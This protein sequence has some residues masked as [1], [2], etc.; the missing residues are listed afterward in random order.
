MSSPPEIGFAEGSEAKQ[1]ELTLLNERF[2]LIF[3]ANSFSQW[4]E[5]MK[6]YGLK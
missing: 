6:K 3:P 2:R 5:I 1:K 4:E